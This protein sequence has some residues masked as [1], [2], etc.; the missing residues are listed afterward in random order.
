M[1]FVGK[2]Q[3]IFYSGGQIHSKKDNLTL[4]GNFKFTRG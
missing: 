3:G 1:E 2:T 4:N